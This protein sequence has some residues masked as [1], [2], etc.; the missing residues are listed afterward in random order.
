MKIREGF[1]KLIT[2]KKIRLLTS[3]NIAQKQ[4][5]FNLLLYASSFL[6]QTQVLHLTQYLLTHYIAFVTVYLHFC[7]LIIKILRILKFIQCLYTLFYKKQQ[8]FDKVQFF[9]FLGFSALKHPYFILSSM[10]LSYLLT[11]KISPDVNKSL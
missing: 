9:F 2:Y 4:M 5:I 6:K 7:L 10:K 8:S 1:F 11:S 3:K